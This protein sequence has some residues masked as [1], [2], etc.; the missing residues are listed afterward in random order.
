MVIWLS[1]AASFVVANWLDTVLKSGNQGKH[2]LILRP[3]GRLDRK[4]QWKLMRLQKSAIPLALILGTVKGD[5]RKSHC[6][7]VIFH[8]KLAL[9]SEMEIDW[10]NNSLFKRLKFLSFY[11]LS[12]KPPLRSR[13]TSP[14]LFRTHGHGYENIPNKST[15]IMFCDR[16][17]CR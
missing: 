2:R 17:R 14:D 7:W 8:R 16:L 1:V 11:Y 10:I 15:L 4:P 13:V 5:G 6:S 3:V 9:Y 12:G